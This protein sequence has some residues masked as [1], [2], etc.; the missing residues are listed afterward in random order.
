MRVGAPRG[1]G[2]GPAVDRMV[3]VVVSAVVAGALTACTTAEPGSAGAAGTPSTYRAP[4]NDPGSVTLPPRPRD[5]P[6]RG[7]DPCTLLTA[8][9]RPGL[10]VL[11][12]TPGQAATQFP[13]ATTCDYRSSDGTPGAVFAV[14]TVTG[15]G[16][17]AWLD[18]TLADNVRQ[19]SVGGFPALDATTKG[20]DLLHGCTTAVS[21]ATGQMLTVQWGLPPRGTTTAQSCARTEQVAG[22]AMTTLQT[23]K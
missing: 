17:A 13:G 5:V 11:A 19:V 12:G 10:G 2:P 9:Q 6:V 7:V 16:V 1:F 3:A 8:A 4:T 22:A 20:T 21:V 14:S 18:P 15:A 23:A